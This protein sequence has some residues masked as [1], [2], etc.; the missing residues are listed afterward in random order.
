MMK[1][2]GTR[3]IVKAGLTPDNPL[4]VY[5]PG[6]ER[7][8]PLDDEEVWRRREAEYEGIAGRRAM[9]E[10]LGLGVVA[11]PNETVLG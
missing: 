10:N 5:T 2:Y 8:R 1:V 11:H 9:Y 4:D 3:G 7:V 6:F